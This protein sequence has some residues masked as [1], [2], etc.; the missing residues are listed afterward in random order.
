MSLDNA[1]VKKGRA[2]NLKKRRTSIVNSI[3]KDIQLFEIKNN[4]E[5]QPVQQA[6]EHIILYFDKSLKGLFCKNITNL[7]KENIELRNQDLNELRNAFDKNT[8]LQPELMYAK[9][10]ELITLVQ[11][12]LKAQFNIDT[13]S[14]D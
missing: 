9:R 12:L 11:P 4:R 14:S 6:V 5:L 1:Q 8:Y 13:I 10:K 2:L 7:W 3:L